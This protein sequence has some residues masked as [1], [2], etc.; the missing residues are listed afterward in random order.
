MSGYIINTR[1]AP[2]WQR[3]KD[4]IIAISVG[5]PYHE[6]A[7]FSA[8]VDW[9]AQRFER[10]HV[11]IGDTLQRHNNPAPDAEAQSKKA[12]DAWLQRNLP[13][14]QATGK[15]ASVTRW[16]EL[17]AQPEFP[18]VLAQFKKAAA[19]NTRLKTALAA[20]TAQFVARQANPLP[21]AAERSRAYV[22]E[23]LAAI[24]LHA[25]QIAGARLYPSKNIQ[26]LALVEAGV[27]PEAPQGLERQQRMH[28]SIRSRTATRLG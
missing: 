3:H 28:L 20:D 12:G 14:V 17:L 2:N 21:D 22:L 1:N 23:E 7:R 4:A 8:I 13:V 16:G 24:T 6:G 10:L 15:L 5:A 25:R 27:I 19:E 9:A 11:Q 18:S 26:S